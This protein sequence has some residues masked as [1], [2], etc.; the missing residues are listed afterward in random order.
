MRKNSLVDSEDMTGEQL[1]TALH[2]SDVLA[3]LATCYGANVSTEQTMIYSRILAKRY[4]LEVIQVACSQ[5]LL[6]ETVKF[7]PRVAQLL[8]FCRKCR[9]STPLSG[10]SS[11]KTE[12]E[13]DYAPFSEEQT[14]KMFSMIRLFY[15]T[16]TPTEIK[17]PHVMSLC[18]M[19]RNGEDTAVN[20]L[21]DSTIAE[22][23]TG[24]ALWN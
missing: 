23:E 8:E 12:K 7:F 5:I 3:E 1:G 10:E 11:A 15:L 9:V 2:A 6:D 22:L 18:M 14:A 13:E 24:K 4:P 21:L 20:A 19:S 16:K 17:S